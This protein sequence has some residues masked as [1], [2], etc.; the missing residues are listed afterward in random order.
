MKCARRENINT[1]KRKSHIVKCIK[2]TARNSSFFFQVSEVQYPRFTLEIDF[3]FEF[4]AGPREIRTVI[5]Y[6]SHRGYNTSNLI[7]NSGLTDIRPAP[8][9]MAKVYLAV[10]CTF[11]RDPS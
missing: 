1:E 3:H 2:F 8:R 4:R 6:C 9:R 7:H 5:F 11:N 10:W